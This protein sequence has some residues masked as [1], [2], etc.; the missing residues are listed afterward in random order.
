MIATAVVAGA[1]ALG[2]LFSMI[3]GSMNASSKMKEVAA[4]QQKIQFEADAAKRFYN[5]LDGLTEGDA[6]K[7]PALVE[8]INSFRAKTRNIGYSY[9]F[10]GNEF[11][12]TY[13][14]EENFIKKY[15]HWEKQT[16]ESLKDAM[17]A[18]G[19]IEKSQR[20][21]V[22]LDNILSIKRNAKSDS[23][24]LH[25]IG[26]I[27]ALQMKQLAELAEIIAVSSRAQ[28]SALTEKIIKKRERQQYEARLMKN[29]N[30]HRPSKPLSRFPSLGTTTN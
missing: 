4:V 20:H 29:F 14:S 3:T 16:D 19:L 18:Q 6:E 30:R 1:T 23:D 22:D 7:L 8:R 13:G 26:E 10:I 25:I 11:D 12:K 17:I 9:A 24:T 27:N 15:H 21:L 5:A 28:Q 2:T